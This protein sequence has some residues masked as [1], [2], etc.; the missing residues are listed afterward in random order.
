MPS[1]SRLVLGVAECA[2]VA[3]LGLQGC[4]VGTL[5]S[6]EQ[7]AA[8]CPWLSCS[9]VLPLFGSGVLLAEAGWFLSLPS[10]WGGPVALLALGWCGVKRCWA[11]GAPRHWQGWSLSL[12]VV[13]PLV[14]GEL[15]ISQSGGAGQGC[16]HGAGML[17]AASCGGCPGDRGQSWL[18]RPFAFP[19]ACSVPW[20]C[21][22]EW[23]PGPCPLGQGGCDLLV[24]TSRQLWVAFWEGEGF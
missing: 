10:L 21:P 20:L 2:G 8:P 17:D 13:L 3:V 16:E 15:S 14:M 6:Q 24:P 4:G 18:G 11:E 7:K 1:M 23:H 12:S 22:P 5:I 9:G 19:K